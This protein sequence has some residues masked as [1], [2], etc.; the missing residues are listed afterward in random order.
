MKKNKKRDFGDELQERFDRWGEIVLNGCG[1]PFWED[2]VNLNLVRN[3]IIHLKNLCEDELKPEEYPEQ[4]YRETP[5]KVDNK[6]IANTDRIAQNAQKSLQML[7]SNKDY[8]FLKKSL[9]RLSTKQCEQTSI[10]NVIAYVD[11]LRSAINNEEY[12][13][14]RLYREPERYLQS[15][16]SCRER[17]EKIFKDRETQELPAG[18]LTLFDIGL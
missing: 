9:N 11:R 13:T 16:E 7:E 14:M 4:Y 8:L 5:P 2:G 12:I 17:V 1:D 3:H 10:R 15:M 18:Q 6:Y